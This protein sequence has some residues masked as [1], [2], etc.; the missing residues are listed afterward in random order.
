[1]HNTNAL[2]KVKLMVQNGEL[3]KVD[4]YK[5]KAAVPLVQI[6]PQGTASVCG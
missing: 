6:S 5:E 3:A 1:L 4:N 2:A